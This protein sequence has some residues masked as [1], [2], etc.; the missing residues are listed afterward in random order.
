[1]RSAASSRAVRQRARAAAN[2]PTARVKPMRRFL[3][4]TAIA[5]LM[6]AFVGAAAAQLLTTHAGVSGAPACGGYQGPGDV[7]SGATAWWGYR[8]YNAAKC[9]TAAVNVCNVS[10]V[11]CADQSTSATTGQLF[12]NTVGGTN[13]VSAGPC[14]NKTL[15]DQ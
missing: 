3:T 12:L 9:G 14:T 15:Y 4:L 2:T 5:M 13:C 6:G 11:V 10:D 8:A 1:M 7:V